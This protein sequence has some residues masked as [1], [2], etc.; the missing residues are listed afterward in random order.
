MVCFAISYRRRYQKQDRIE[1]FPR[2]V[3]GVVQIAEI[4]TRAKFEMKMG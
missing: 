4:F 3:V 2:K 1:F